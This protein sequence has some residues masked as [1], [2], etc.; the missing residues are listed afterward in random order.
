MVQL[1]HY[2]FFIEKGYQLNYLQFFLKDFGGVEDMCLNWRSLL[3]NLLLSLPR[4]LLVAPNF[5][6]NSV[7]QTLSFCPRPSQA[8]RASDHGRRRAEEQRSPWPSTYQIESGRKPTPLTLFRHEKCTLARSL[9]LSH[10][11]TRT[12]TSYA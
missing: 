1:I 5:T 4:T 2:L 11:L 10:C 9:A 12:Y 6:Q 3:D 8:D 7:S